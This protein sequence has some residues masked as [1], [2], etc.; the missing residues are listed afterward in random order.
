LR[1]M[2][3]AGGTA[4]NTNT[5][6]I[7]TA[8]ASGDNAIALGAEATASGD[9]SMSLMQSNAV[10]N[11][12]FATGWGTYA[13]GLYSTAIGKQS[14]ASGNSAV[15]MGYNTI[16]SG[17]YSTAMG[18]STTAS[19]FASTAMG[20]QC[21]ATS[22]S[23]TAFGSACIASG[24]S[25]VSMG[26][27]N[28]SESF[29]S[30]AMNADNVATSSAGCATVMGRY[31]IARAGFSLV[32]GKFNDTTG[33]NTLFEIGN[34]TGLNARSNAVTVIDNGNVGIGTSFPGI[35]LDVLSAPNSPGIRL[36]TGSPSINTALQVGR[37]APDITIGVAAVS[38]NYSTDATLAGDAIIRSESG[39]NKLLLQSGSGA[40]AMAI[41]GANVG[42]NTIAPNS[43]LQ[44]GG[45]FASKNGNQASTATTAGNG[46]AL[47]NSY[48]IEL[49]A[50][51]ANA[52]FKLPAANTCGGRMYLLFN[53]SG[54]AAI[55]EAAGGTFFGG[56]GTSGTTT[57]T[58]P[59]VAVGR[60][61]HVVSD[62]N[63]WL[64][65]RYQ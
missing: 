9:F 10:G 54:N 5:I 37:A 53:A 7:G 12:S 34:G 18:S 23:A 2:A 8:D 20:T 41:V 15:A 26:S 25:S 44:V 56:D 42:V 38:G 14:N 40:S 33:V 30:V 57:F 46:V 65:G 19:G 63:N 36:L 21:S 51:V 3:F 16:A 58:M 13:N 50:A 49:N 59:A 28:K 6:A 35:R 1:S 32:A 29:A 11:F 62:G 52:R 47:D 48:F 4:S 39:A 45:T 27:L 60:F 61:V 43:S 55:I 31:N 24:S 17:D 22:Q 64:W